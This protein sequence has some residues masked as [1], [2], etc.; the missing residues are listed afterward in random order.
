MAITREGDGSNTGTGTSGTVAVGTGLV[1]DLLVLLIIVSGPTNI[2]TVPTGY[3]LIRQTGDSTGRVTTCYK[4]ATVT[5]E[6]APVAPFS[7]SGEWIMD[8]LRYRPIDTVIGAANMASGSGSSTS[9]ASEVLTMSGGNRLVV[10]AARQAGNRAVFS[11]PTN[12]HSI[13]RQDTGGN[14]V[15]VLTEAFPTTGAA[16]QT[17]V[18]S[19]QNADWVSHIVHFNEGAPPPVE[20]DLVGQSDGVADVPD[21]DLVV[22]NNNLVILRRRRE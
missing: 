19:D 10:H 11:S 13:A 14:A 6:A 3:T 21:A 17:T 12:G 16:T 5:N 20:H 9:V 15:A 2:I 4:F 22:D 18:T 7:L 8:F 1:D